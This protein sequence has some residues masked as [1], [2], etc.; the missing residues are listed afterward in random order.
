M[1]DCV[2]VSDSN[3]QLALPSIFFAF[4][5]WWKWQCAGGGYCVLITLAWLQL[6][7]LVASSYLAIDKICHTTTQRTIALFL[8][9]TVSGA[10][11]L[12]Q[13][14]CDLLQRLHVFNHTPCLVESIY[15]HWVYRVDRPLWLQ[16]SLRWAYFFLNC[17]QSFLLRLWIVTML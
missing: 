1:S 16:R 7:F 3:S 14:S 4:W 5:R 10:S 17:S 8:L 13:R 12:L 15:V 6:S 9:H 11:S 2:R